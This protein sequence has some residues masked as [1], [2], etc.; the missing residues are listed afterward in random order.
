MAL[1]TTTTMLDWRCTLSVKAHPL[2]CLNSF[3]LQVPHLNIATAT[4]S[5]R[6]AL[7][8]PQAQ[9]AEHQLAEQVLHHA[10]KAAF[11]IEP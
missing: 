6:L 2:P 4:S 3:S 9:G 1:V 10:C 8:T 7:Q 5:Q 11:A